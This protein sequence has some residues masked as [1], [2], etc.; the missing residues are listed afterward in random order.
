MA[1][2]TVLDSMRGIYCNANLRGKHEPYAVIIHKALMSVPDRK[3][4]VTDIYKF[5]ER[6][7]PARAANGNG[8]RNS[9]RHNL[10]M[11]GVSTPPSC[12]IPSA[13]CLETW[14]ACV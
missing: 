13:P 10:S 7:Q 2:E 5:F 1:V 8:W 14:V 9:I 12:P 11:N 4:I 6:T 3:M